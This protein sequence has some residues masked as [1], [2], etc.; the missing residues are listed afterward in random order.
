MVLGVVFSSA[1]QSAGPSAFSGGRD[2]DHVPV[3]VLTE[4]VKQIGTT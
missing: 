2:V 1:D 3:H 4:L